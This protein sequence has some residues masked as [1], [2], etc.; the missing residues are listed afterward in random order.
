M[1][2]KTDLV[3]VLLTEISRQ[4]IRSL[5]CTKAYKAYNEGTCRETEAT[6]AVKTEVETHIITFGIL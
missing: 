2:Q 6:R 4:V 3:F 1:T 5:I